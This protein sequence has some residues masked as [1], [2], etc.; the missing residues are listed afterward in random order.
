MSQFEISFDFKYP[1]MF[2]QF[3]HALKFLRKKLKFF[4]K[5]EENRIIWRK[6]LRACATNLSK[7]GRPKDI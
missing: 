4:L 6:K 7:R 2:R 5:M 1:S 3:F